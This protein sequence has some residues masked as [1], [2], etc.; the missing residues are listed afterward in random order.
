MP[1][2][3]ITHNVA[4]MDI[5]LAGKAERAEAIG[6]MGGA[7]VV[8]HVALDGSNSIAISLDTDD[9]AGMMATLAAPTPEMVEVM[10]RHGVVP[11]L[12]AY[13]EK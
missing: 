13:V 4:D 10:G 8:D 7:N 1:K 3:V 6:G 9:V 2:V 12:A 5:W 11:P